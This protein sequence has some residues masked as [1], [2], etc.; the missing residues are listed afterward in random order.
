AEVVEGGLPDLSFP[1]RTAPVA[2]E[3]APEPVVTSEVV[4]GEPEPQSF[5]SE[6]AAE[7]APAVA[8]SQA[9][10]LLSLFVPTANDAIEWE[11]GDYS[12]VARGGRV[13]SPVRS[14]ELK[15][16]QNM[17]AEGSVV[18]AAVAPRGSASD[19]APEGFP[20]PVYRTGFAV[21]IP[22]PAA[23]G[24]NGHGGASS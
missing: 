13:E 4:E 1:P 8:V 14:G 10:W 18:F 24:R 2:V 20:H 5:W 23:P 19:V 12:M 3:K 21:A 6:P 22:L 16:L 9:Y 17:V 11:R 15:K 7:P